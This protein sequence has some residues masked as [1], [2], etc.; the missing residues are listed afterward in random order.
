MQES[1]LTLI[2]YG[3][4]A[5]S[6][7]LLIAELFA[8]S[9][10]LLVFALAAISAGLGLTFY[11]SPTLGLAT[12]FA[13]FIVI[14]IFGHLLL[15]IWPKTA[16]GKKFFMS[17]PEEDATV[18]SMPVN[19]ELESLRGRFGRTLAPHRPAGITDFDGKRVDTLSE[20]MMID[21]GAWVRCID[22]KSGKVI[23]RPMDAPDLEKLEAAEL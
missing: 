21:A 19:L 11:A 12:T 9:G 3:L 14:P 13:L 8:P 10:I 17:G 2:A 22:V 23:V 1:E 16:A 6:L 18:A 5:L 4:I 7:I 20:G 15:Q